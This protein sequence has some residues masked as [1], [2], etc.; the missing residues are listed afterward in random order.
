MA[1][2]AGCGVVIVVNKWDL[3]EAKETM[4]A[5]HFEKAA[6]ERAPFLQWVPFLFTS[7]KT[8]QRV[9]KALDV[10][11]EVQ[12]QRMRRIDTHEVNEALEELVKRQPPPHSRGRA[13]KLRYATQVQVE[14]PTFVL[15]SN[16]PREIPD[17]YLRYLM[18]G[19]RDKW[20]FTGSP[21]RLQL[22]ASGTKS[23]AG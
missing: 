17:H 23:Q 20:D 10:V 9:H 14:P 16:L 15:F 1:W 5:P 13:I 7:A 22:R 6:G 18:N 21:I 2:E 11:L 12:A 19:F 4:T 3:V 8:G